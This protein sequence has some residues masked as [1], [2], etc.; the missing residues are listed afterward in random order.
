MNVFSEVEIQSKA[1]TGFLL[2][3]FIEFA[4]NSTNWIYDEAKSNMY[5]E[6]LLD[7]KGCILIYKKSKFIPGFAFYEKKEGFFY[8]AN[9]VPKEI[10]R[11]P[12][13]EYNALSRKFYDDFK[14]WKKEKNIE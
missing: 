12:L 10:G 8:I 2:D 1:G 3:K 14:K 4:T 13:Q 7:S 6:N 11:I 5:S 9:I